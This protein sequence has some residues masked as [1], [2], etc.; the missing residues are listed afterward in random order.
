MSKSPLERALKADIKQAKLALK[1]Y[2]NDDEHDALMLLAATAEQ[3]LEAVKTLAKMHDTFSDVV[4]GGNVTWPGLKARKKALRLFCSSSA[5]L[6][7]GDSEEPEYE[8]TSYFNDK[9]EKVRE[10]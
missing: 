5:V 3:A 10:L 7:L 4:E 2:S 9:G 6:A 8:P 1:G